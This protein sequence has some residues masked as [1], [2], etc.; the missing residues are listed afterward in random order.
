MTALDAPRPLAG[1]RV[2]AWEQAVALPMATRLLANLGATVVR[3]ESHH[4]TQPRPRYLAN[5]LI[6]DKQSIALDLTDPAARAVAKRLAATADVFCENFTPRVKRQFGL[7]YED[8][9]EDNPGLVMLSLSGYGQTGP[10]SD[11]P[12]YGPGIEAASGHALSAGFPD[13]PPTRPGTVVY[14]D[15]ISGWYATLAVLGALARRKRTGEGA[16]IDLAMY[17]ANAFHLGPVI[18]RSS[19]T[20]QPAPR[21][22]NSDEAALLQD[23]FAAAGDERWLAVTVY[24]GQ[25]TA[26]RAVIGRAESGVPLRDALA[27]WAATQDATSAAETLQA[28]G[29]AAAPVLDAK[30]LLLN[31]HLDARGAFSLVEHAAP[32]HGYPAHPHAGLPWRTTGHDEPAIEEAPAIGEHSRA[33]LGDWLDMPATEIDAL[34]ASGA[35]GEHPGDPPERGRTPPETAAR[36]LDWRLISGYDG[37]PEER[38]GLETGGAW[39]AT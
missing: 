33:V 12:T 32:V 37:N 8:L 3:L 38:I 35:L 18:A 39:P 16:Y 11:R 1:I 14:A 10:W 28:A 24:P 23:V 21:R 22:G 7:A 9:R 6:Q 26:A 25:D 29:I 30:D 2:L 19:I 15:N 5:D 4:R 20:G 36:R 34:F 31:S 13:A 17:E 27:S